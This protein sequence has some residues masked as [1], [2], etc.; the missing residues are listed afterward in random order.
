MFIAK[1]QN[2]IKEKTCKFAENFVPLQPIL[3]E[4]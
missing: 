1:Y 3:E 4:I 2:E